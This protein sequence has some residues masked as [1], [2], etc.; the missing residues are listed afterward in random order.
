MPPG[1]GG[2]A[3]GD[4]EVNHSLWV[5]HLPG[6]L[7]QVPWEISLGGGRRL[8]R[9]GPQLSEGTAEV[10]VAVSGADQGV[11]RCPDLREDL[12]G[13]GSGS[14]S[15]RVGYVGNDTTHWDSFGRIPPQGI[16]QADGETT[17]ERTGWRMVVSPAG[18]SDTRGGITESGY[19]YI[20]PPENSCTV[21]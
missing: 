13:G 5:P 6:H 14:H 15:L 10:G 16:P 9:S 8:A 21:N 2:V 20:P 7:L 3:D 1:E 11:R 18:G 12:R 17:S 19:L 4:R